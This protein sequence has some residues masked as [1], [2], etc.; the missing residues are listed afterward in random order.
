M[1]LHELVDLDVVL[2]VGIS[3]R[4]QVW[5]VEHSQEEGHQRGSVLPCHVP[6][7]GCP[8]HQL[9]ASHAIFY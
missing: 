1:H 5:R 9:Y 7:G 8:T 6:G 3:C 2:Q 4:L